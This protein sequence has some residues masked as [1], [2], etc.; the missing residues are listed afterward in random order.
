MRHPITPQHIRCL[1]LSSSALTGLAFAS[2]AAAGQPGL[3][4]GGVVTAGSATI[5]QPSASQLAITTATSRTVIDW[6]SFSIGSGNKVAIQQPGSSSITVNE[7]TGPNPSQIFGELSS[8]GRVV[9]A[10]PNGIWFGPDAHVDVA[11]LV[12]STATLSDASRKA[13]ASGGR[14]SLDTA[15]KAN[16]SIQNDG[17]ITIAAEGLAALVAPGVRNNG[18]IQATLG[19]VELASGTTSTL[20]FYGDGL[21]SMAVTTPVAAV[22]IGPDGKPFQATIENNG[23][24]KA[25]QVLVTADAVKG[26]VDN[27]VNMSGAIEAK[28]VTVSGGDIVLDGGDGNVTVS[29]VLDASSQQAKGGS[30]TVTG[31]AVTLASTSAINVSGATG[32]GTVQVGGGPHGGGTLKHATSTTVAAGASVKANATKQGNGGTVSVW[33][34]GLTSFNGSIQAKGAGSGAGGSVETSG[35]ALSIGGGSVVAGSWLLDPTDLT[36]DTGLA[37]SIETSLDAGTNVTEQTT[38]SGT[39]GSGDITVAAPISWT[40]GAALSLSAYRNIAVDAGLTSTGGGSVTLHADN[41]GTG[42]GTVSFADAAKVTTS[43]VVAIFYNPSDNPAGSLVNATSY[44]SPTDYTADVAGGATLTASMLVN[45][46]YDLQNVQNNLAGDYALGR[47]IDAS[48]TAG[49]NGGAGFT[50]IGSGSAPFAGSFNGEGYSIANVTINLPNAAE[51]GLFAVNTGPLTSMTLSGVT[52][53]GGSITGG[54]SGVNKST[55]S[56]S[57]VSG[58]VSLYAG[59]QDVAARGYGIAIGGLVGENNGT[60]KTSSSSGM[61]LALSPGVLAT[62]AGGLVGVNAGSLSQSFS[63]AAV[64]AGAIT[65]S[66]QSAAA[67]G[68]VGANYG[69]IGYSYA[70]GAVSAVAGT[71]TGAQVFGGG[72]VG[73]NIGAVTQSYATGT[74][75]GSNPGASC[76]Y[77]SC[78]VGVSA[79]GGLVGYNASTGSITYSYALGTAVDGGSS[80]YS[81]VVDNNGDTTG[82][83]SLSDTGGL[84]GLNA[85]NIS[86]TYSSG[87]V[88]QTTAGDA[89]GGLIGVNSGAITQSHWDVTTSG[90]AT[91]AGGTGLTTAQMSLQTSYGSGWNFASPW[92]LIPGLAHPILRT[93]LSG[94]V[95]NTADQLELIG[96]NGATLAAHYTLS[97]DL[98]LTSALSSA[99]GHWLVAGNAGLDGGSYGF[100]PIGAPVNVQPAQDFTGSLNGMGHAINGLA[101]YEYEQLAGLFFYLTGTVT[102]LGLTNVSVSG[103][104]AGGI[105]PYNIETISNSYVTGTVTG[106]TAAGGLTYENYGQILQ[107]YSAAT[108]SG[109]TVAAGIATENSGLI[110][111]SYNTGS[112][113]GALAGGGVEQNAGVIDRSYNTGTVSGT[114]VPGAPQKAIGGLVGDNLGPGQISN[115]YSTGS[116]IGGPEDIVTNSPQFVGGLVGVNNGLIQASYASGTVEPG[117]G[118]ATVGGLV[119]FSSDTTIISSYSTATVTDANGGANIGGLIGWLDGGTLRDSFATGM[120]TGAGNI[121]GLVGVA[122]AGSAL[123]NTYATGTVVATGDLT[124]AGGLIGWV[125]FGSVSSSYST[126]AVTANTTNANVG[127]LIGYT[128][129]A[130]IT[131]SYSSDTVT[132]TGNANSVGGLIGRHYGSSLDQSYATGAVTSTGSGD[133]V[134]GLVGYA[135]V[136]GNITN[137]YATGAV[138]GNGDHTAVG[139][140]V[141]Y[142]FSSSLATS[143]S[144]GAVTGTGLKQSVYY[145]YGG[146]VGVDI[147]GTVTQSYWDID[148]SGQATSAAGT[149]LTAAELEAALPPGFSPT[150]WGIDAGSG[151]PYL[152]WQTSP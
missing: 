113:S 46:V 114:I 10:N 4:T 131:K 31:G 97:A 25:G 48:A 109:G 29:G 18:V 37:A 96:Q 21:V 51:L 52:I 132:G 68:L 34:D 69:S 72:L 138:T 111:Q 28:G 12:A 54:L 108:V 147:F 45:S 143:Y 104:F 56:G 102:N 144:T 152:L 27:T 149:G 107:S 84:V 22:A 50:P 47:N 121:G 145:G 88:Q 77:V 141:G 90:Q 119:G 39:G 150:I 146:L 71:S 8:N 117:N 130:V 65:D 89:V 103:S 9:L 106:T 6:Q 67:G 128:T 129:D 81:Y 82:G 83:Q 32:G 16:A 5:A 36:I 73:Y 92:Y 53:N 60:V 13:F 86:I 70:T 99:S 19:T 1:L 126:G 57:S 23:K 110:E 125:D 134:G 133:R 91:S 137:S 120:V 3:P 49:W 75:T 101:I 33:S 64:V 15:G 20:D 112:V 95:I 93:E 151:Y 42:T 148:T 43:G 135:W 14:L 44:T 63:S 122:T 76:S 78:D 98:D 59:G 124:F 79:V 123:T 30:V 35:H 7:V 136:G 116:V 115:S 40:T 61:V 11:G 26:V 80:S 62:A 87:A 41:T 139:G 100:I 85:G 38:L 58:T 142:L 55:I 105:S 2:A 17:H 94:T 127:G 66:S 140:L 74:V 24:I 118:P